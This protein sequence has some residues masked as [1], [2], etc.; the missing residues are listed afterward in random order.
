MK[1]GVLALQGDVPE[2]L[3]ALR[4]VLPGEEVVPVRTP[5]ELAEVSALFMPGGESTT[6]ARLLVQAGLWNPLG[7]RIKNG[8]PVLATCAGLIL[9]AR[10]LVPGLAGMDPPT[11]GLLDV[12]VRRNDY[13][14]Q[15][16][17]FEAPVHVEGLSGGPFPG[18]FIRSPRIHSFGPGVTAF[19]WRGGEVVGVRAGMIWGLAFHPELSGDPRLHHLFIEAARAASR[20]PIARATRSRP[21]RR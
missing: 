2:H 13:G 15:G 12:Q 11:F 18:V 3:A 9:L 10:E 19:A 6:I 4:T 5:S 8:L 7:E 14:S 16:E 21:K 20:A 1:V 17:S